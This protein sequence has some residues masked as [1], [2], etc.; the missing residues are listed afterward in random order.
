M[1]LTKI[2]VHYRYFFLLLLIF[3]IA[4]V[5]VN[6]FGNFPLNDDWSYSKSVKILL[7]ENEINI[8]DWGAMTL[9]TQILWG[10]LWTK[11]FGFSF[12]VLRFSTLFSACLGLFF[13]FQ[14]TFRLSQS[15]KVSFWC[16]L[17]FLFTPLF[18][19]LSNTFMT[20]VNFVSLLLVFVFISQRYLQT[21]ARWLI[22]PLF[23]VTLLL[24]FLRQFGI[25]APVAFIITLVLKKPKDRL[26]TGLLI[27]LVLAVLLCLKAYEAHLRTYLSADAPYKFSNSL[28]IGNPDFLHR[29][30]DNFLNRYKTI[31]LHLLVYTAPF[32]VLFLRSVIGTS[33]RTKMVIAF[34]LS[35]GASCFIIGTD[36]LLCGNVVKNMLVG[37]ET[38]YASLQN[39]SLH[40]ASEN[41]AVILPVVI[42]LFSTSTLFVLFLLISR[43]ISSLFHQPLPLFCLIF[44]IA[45]SVL[46]LV[47]E[48]FFDRYHL[49]LIVMML[50]ILSALVRN[51]SI[52]FTPGVIM[53]FL[54][55]YVSVAGTKDYLSWNTKRWQAY[56]GLR[57]AGIP[58]REINAGFEVNCWSDGEKKWWTNV[59]TLEGYTY[60]IQFENEKGYTPVQQF[61]FQRYYPFRSDTLYV[62]QK[63]TA[64]IRTNP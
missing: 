33:S 25:I 32:S 43:N 35:F 15:S 4:E 27:V 1:V 12:I 49:P 6:P 3:F 31:L 14:I 28:G 53:L 5:L 21:Q 37:P 45:Y 22:L 17:V 54:F 59:L 60:L 34:L 46:L 20:D 64:E 30:A 26:G 55:M 16:C 41:F 47:A 24:T 9:V 56:E 18:F 57:Q 63:D 51:H 13:L 48:S 50:V 19:N 58:V 62:F 23:A 29:L 61:P 39:N 38:F 44:I 40:N 36:A 2:P 7:E 10:F 8:G 42:C 52:H 11:I